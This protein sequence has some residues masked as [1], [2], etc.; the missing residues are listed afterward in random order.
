MVTDIQPAMHRDIPLAAID[1]ADLDRR[2]NA[3]LIIEQ[4]YIRFDIRDQQRRN[5]NRAL[6]DLGN[7]LIQA[8]FPCKMYEGYK[9]VNDTRPLGLIFQHPPI[10]EGDRRND[11]LLFL[12]N[13]SLPNM[14]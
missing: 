4:D 8:F 1:K 9:V 10:Y 14:I 3:D 12:T 2:L 11:D 5:R 6:R 7:K 13:Y